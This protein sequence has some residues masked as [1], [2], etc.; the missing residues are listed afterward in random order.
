MPERKPSRFCPDSCLF[1]KDKDVECP[2]EC[3]HQDD[4]EY[5]QPSRIELMGTKNEWEDGEVLGH[6]ERWL[7]VRDS[8]GEESMLSKDSPLKRKSR[9]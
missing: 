6:N 5:T 1:P 4:V 3:H 2:E 9:E 7:Y 8:K